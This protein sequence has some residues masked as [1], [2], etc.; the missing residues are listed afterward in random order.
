MR[1]T[2]THTHTDIATTRSN[3]PSG[4]LQWKHRILTFC[5]LQLQLQQKKPSPQKVRTLFFSQHF[6]PMT[7]TVFLWELR[8][9]DYSRTNF[10]LFA[11]AR[12][13]D[14]HLRRQKASCTASDRTKFYLSV[15]DGATK[16]AWELELVRMR[17]WVWV[18][19]L[20]CSLVDPWVKYWQGQSIFGWLNILLVTPS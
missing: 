13:L 17:A 18:W 9:S 3:R 16:W 5:G 20:G 10:P 14:T 2:Q 15:W 1:D 12:V 4:P 8:C 7:G 11:G 6:P 19:A